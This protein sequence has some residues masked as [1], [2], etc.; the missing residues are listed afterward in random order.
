MNKIKT[1]QGNIFFNDWSALD[2]EIQRIN[3][4]K[5]F[6][7]VDQNTEKYCL[8]H[9]LEHINKPVS[10]IRISS[11]EINKSLDSC[12]HVWKSLL[13]KGADR[14]ALLI[15]LG[16]GIISDL[17]GFCAGTYMRGI[18]F[19][20]IPTTL[21]S[22]V[23]ASIGGKTGIDFLGIKNIV[24]LFANPESVFIF[25]PFLSTL[26]SNEL[27]S[28]YAELLKH[29][30]I[31]DKNLWNNLITRDCTQ[32][33]NIDALI[34]QSILIKKQIT[35]KDPN[36][37]GL[38]KILNFGHTIGH[39][40]EAYWLDSNTSLLHGEAVAIGMVSEAFIAYRMDLIDESTL[41]EIRRAMLRIYGHYPRY[42]KS[43]NNLIAL[44]RS[45]KKNLNEEIRFALLND[46]G[47]CQ[48]DIYVPDSII[49]EGLIFYSTVLKQSDLPSFSTT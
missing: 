10:I 47:S 21:L 29:G 15:N 48:Y 16:G 42:V 34:Y 46:I 2:K 25:T 6:I 32:I 40:I 12:Q 36:E 38:R 14:N 3:P 24:G 45:D 26:P 13:E 27:K 35:D 44:M 33:D 17:G 7:L 20:H 30:L 11:G 18:K 23:D 8:F 37:S 1:K 5:I 41:F 28:G 22:Q 19:I 43:V 39:A 4:S 9:L 31:G 49:E